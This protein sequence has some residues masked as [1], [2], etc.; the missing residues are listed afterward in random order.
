MGEE[1][2]DYLS[3]LIDDDE[4][5]LESFQEEK[6]EHIEKPKRHIKKSVW[7]TLAILLVVALG[8]IYGFFLAPKIEMPNFVGKK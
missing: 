4:T 3:S 5:T 7:V 8:A 6:V 2:K 1:K